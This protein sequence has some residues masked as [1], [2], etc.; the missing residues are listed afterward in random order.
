MNWSL[1]FCILILLPIPSTFLNEGMGSYSYGLPFKFIT[2][3]QRE[4]NSAWLFGNLFNGNAGMAVNPGSFAVNV[5]VVY[6][7]VRFAANKL[8]KKREIF[9][10]DFP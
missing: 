6:L 7:I 2:I 3:Y 5:G 4:P 8:S 10:N 1:L 9:N